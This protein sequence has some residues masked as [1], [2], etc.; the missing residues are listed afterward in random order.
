MCTH[1]LL[2][3]CVIISCRH[4]IYSHDFLHSCAIV[5]RESTDLEDL[6]IAHIGNIHRLTH[7]LFMVCV[8]IIHPDSIS[9]DAF[10]LCGVGAMDCFARALRIAAQ[11][12]QDGHLDNL[13]K[14][15][16]A[17][18]TTGIGAQ[19][20]AGKATLEDCEAYVKKEGQGLFIRNAGSM[21]RISFI[22]FIGDYFM[23]M[24]SIHHTHPCVMCVVCVCGVYQVNLKSPLV[25]KKKL[26]C[27]SINIFKH[28]CTQENL[29]VCM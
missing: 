27:Y 2:D 21:L 18:F 3:R 28:T 15:R 9:N 11:I 4:D 6:F 19:I 14:Q 29:I 16:Y 24:P 13:V 12:I 17:S 22:H 26:K 8:C 10:L 7:T 23:W 20:A 5:R 25:N 1:H